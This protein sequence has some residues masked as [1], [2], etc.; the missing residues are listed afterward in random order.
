MNCVNSPKCSI[1]NLTSTAHS[2]LTLDLSRYIFHISFTF[3]QL[4]ME[5][6]PCWQ[7][8]SCSGTQKFPAILWNW[9]LIIMFKRARHWSLCWNSFIMFTLSH[10]TYF[11]SVLKL[12]SHI[13]QV[14][15]L[16]CFLQFLIQKSVCALV[17]HARV[18][19]RCPASVHSPAT[20]KSNSG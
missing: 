9:K 14:A 2:C 1:S 17:S 12:F 13:Q 16:V 18:D 10:H 6:S 15:L 20:E 4:S 19:A 5:L 8:N 7:V 11:I 3:T